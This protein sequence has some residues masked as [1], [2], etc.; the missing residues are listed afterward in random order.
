MNR[1]RVKKIYVDVDDVVSRTTETYPRIVASEFGKTVSFDDLTTFDLRASFQ[2]TDNEFHYFFD[3][4]HQ[5]E[6]L[7]SFDPVAGAVEG[8]RAWAEQGHAIDI[9]T[10]R[11]TSAREVTLAW[12]DR[13]RVPYENFIMVD[14]YSRPGNDPAVAVSKAELAG[15]HYDLAVE[16]SADMALFLAQNMGVATALI[17]KPWNRTCPDHVKIIRC[18]T[19]EEIISRW[20]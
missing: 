5:E 16:D 12:L 7:I 8:L 6:L 9:V 1:S 14:K 11:P 19:W 3:R 18:R 17:D 15:R 13:H 20:A 4:V 2:L 10:G